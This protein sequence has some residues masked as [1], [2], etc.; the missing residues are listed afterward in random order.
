MLMVS[1]FNLLLKYIQQNSLF[2]TNLEESSFIPFHQFGILRVLCDSDA[3][4]FEISMSVSVF[5][6]V[7]RGFS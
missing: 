6:V 2:I 7:V 5:I 3:L 4:S 1:S